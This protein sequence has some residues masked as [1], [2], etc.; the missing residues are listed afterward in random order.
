LG[1]DDRTVIAPWPVKETTMTSRMWMAAILAM[2]AAGAGCST[3]ATTN[4]GAP[5]CMS[6]SV[7]KYDP[8]TGKPY[9]APAGADTGGL[10]SAPGED[11]GSGA[12]VPAQDLVGPK[13]DTTLDA[14]AP[15]DAAADVVKSDPFQCPPETPNAA[16]GKHGTK[17][18]Q[19]S[20][21]MY[22]VCVAGAPLA[23]YNQDIKFCT[24]NC[25]CP[26]AAANC[27]ADDTDMNN[28]YKCVI[29][30]T[31]IGGNPGRDGSKPTVNMCARVCQK[32]ADCLAWNPDMPN[33]LKVSNK[34]VSVPSGVCGILQP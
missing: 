21:C 28:T 8:A 34:F 10:D 19:N 31:K 18:T 30:K 7:I 1:K 11:S 25:N 13:A 9:C 26:T 5:T 33:C 24:K 12:D 17:C 2:A 32:D 23:G 29:E 4:A 15:K 6:G 27:Y 3:P 16:L 14:T 20:D 22:G